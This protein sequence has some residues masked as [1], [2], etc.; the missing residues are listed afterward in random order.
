MSGTGFN[1]HETPE[2][3]QLADKYGLT[4]GTPDGLDDI[5]K[6]YGLTPPTH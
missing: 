5:V 2:F 6:R 4:Y 3:T 1:L